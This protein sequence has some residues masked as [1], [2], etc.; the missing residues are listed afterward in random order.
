[1]KYLFAAILLLVGVGYWLAMMPATPQPQGEYSHQFYQPGSAQVITEHVELVDTS[2]PTQANQKFPGSTERRFKGKIWRP[3]QPGHASP[4]L[5]YSHGFM[6]FY[7]EGN[8]LNR[9]LASHGYTVIAVNYPLTNFFAPGGSL[10]NDMV[11]QPADV[12]FLIDY[13]LKRN[14]TVNDSLFQSLNPEQ[15]AVA[16]VS[17]GGMTSSLVGYHPLLRDSRIKA[18]I[19]IAGLSENFTPTFFRH[20]STPFLMIAGTADAILPYPVHAAPIPDKNPQAILVSLKDGSHAGFASPAASLLRF[21][22]NP[23]TLGCNRVNQGLK[24]SKP[25]N[26]NF[27]GNYLGEEYGFVLQYNNSTPRCAEPPIA[28]SMPAAKQHMYT[29]LAAFSFLQSV[30]A[31]EANT[32]DQALRYLT[33]QL[34]TENAEVNVSSPHSRAATENPQP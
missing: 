2:R 6:S 21:Y 20:S 13:M 24:N 8:Y 4:L 26:E 9:F 18:V 5:V 11:N 16:G 32:R 22:N 15:I 25:D 33:E 1:M 30:F 23:D 12:S 7:E 19:S 31:P 17:L 34:A 10:I 14:A 27:M 28:H 29:K 3:F